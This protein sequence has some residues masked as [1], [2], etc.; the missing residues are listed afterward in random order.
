MAAPRSAAPLRVLAVVCVVLITHGSLY[1]WNLVAPASFADAFGA[2]MAQRRWTSSFGDC[3]GNIALFVP[4]GL[5]WVA[6][7]PPDQGLRWRGLLPVLAAA[8][9][10]AWLLQVLQLYAPPRDPALADVLWNGV[11]LLLGVACAALL[12]APLARIATQTQAPQRP[13]LVL[14]ALWLA[15]EWFPF[16]PTIDWQHVKDALKPLLLEPSWRSASAADA[17]LGV[18]V[19]ALLLRPWRQRAALLWALV[20]L[21]A[22]GKLFVVGQA[23]SLSHAAGFAVGLLGAPFVW[24]LDARRADLWGV[25]AILVWYTLDGLRPFDLAEVSGRLHWIP[26]TA[27]LEGSLTANVVAFGR[28]VF[29]LGAV[30]VLGVA[31]GARVGGLALALSVWALLL[32]LLQTQL[33]GRIADATVALIP[34]LWLPVLAALG[35]TPAPPAWPAAAP[36]RS[37][38]RR[39][40]H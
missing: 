31:I 4:L 36:T 21:A 23:I 25:L 18:L 24:R 37:R 8:L 12:R 32:E 10:F 7:R 22:A 3:V 2:L 28:A 35:G 30:L 29:W 20:A 17:A 26:F 16:V 11:G 9:V 40:R 6:A 5:L 1:P 39:R 19:V 14:V 13:A 38:R 15:L 34:W 33:P 27:L